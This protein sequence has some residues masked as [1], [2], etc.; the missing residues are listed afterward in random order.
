[1]TKAAPQLNIFSIGF[2]MAQIMGLLIIWLTMGNFGTHFQ[3]QWDRAQIF[4][5][6]LLQICP[7]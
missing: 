3:M 5:C 1:M 6:Q 4:M 2:A 7:T